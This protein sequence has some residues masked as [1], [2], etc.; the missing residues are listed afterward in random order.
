MPASK[1]SK[2][3]ENE[4]V[5]ENK[6]FRSDAQYFAD[7]AALGHA[8]RSPFGMLNLTL[9]DCVA[10]RETLK[11]STVDFEASKAFFND[12]VTEQLEKD[13]YPNNLEK[14]DRMV[15]LASEFV[16]KRMRDDSRPQEF[17]PLVA[18]HAALVTLCELQQKKGFAIDAAMTNLALFAQ[19][20]MNIAWKPARLKAALDGWGK[21]VELTSL[22][23]KNNRTLVEANRLMT[24]FADFG[25]AQRDAQRTRASKPREKRITESLTLNDLIRQLAAK[26]EN[27]D[28]PAKAIWPQFFSALGRHDCDPS[29]DTAD[30]NIE[31]HF[32]TFI[33]A[34]GKKSKLTFGSFKTMLSS[35][36]QKN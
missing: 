23:Q 13:G 27:E 2:E 28:E 4:S 12:A 33:L 25:A 1:K 31:K 16:G 10:Q 15:L 34:N 17:W 19:A 26:P 35:N 7:Q 20:M 24:P 8:F 3:K 11:I 21:Q 29:E 22:Q 14:V 5:S 30:S 32:Y 6:P 36:R 18:C 9:M